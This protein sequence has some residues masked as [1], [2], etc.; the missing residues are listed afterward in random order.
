MSTRDNN[1]TM[2]STAATGAAQGGCP[3]R[4]R[5]PA[6]TGGRETSTRASLAGTFD[7]PPSAATGGWWAFCAQAG[8][9]AGRG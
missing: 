4:S 3:A 6:A 7:T 1:S 9:V 2:P 8:T 5:A